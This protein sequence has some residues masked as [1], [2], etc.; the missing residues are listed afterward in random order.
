MKVVS[1]ETLSEALIEIIVHF[2]V[3]RSYVADQGAKPSSADQSVISLAIKQASEHCQTLPKAIFSFIQDVLLK[4][5][6][7][8]SAKDFVARFQQLTGPVMAKG[9]EDTAFYCFNRLISLNE[10]GGNPDRLGMEDIHK[11]LQEKQRTFPHSQLATATH[12][13]KR[14]EDVRARLNLL[15]EIPESWI[16]TVNRW[17]AMNECHRRKNFPD[18]N[19]EYLFYQTLVGAWPLTV[20][21]AQQYMEKAAL[22]SGQH[23]NWLQRNHEYEKALQD[24]ISESL[25]D[26][27]FTTDLEAFT[28]T[29][30]NAAAV[31]SLA[32][33]LV[34]LL[35][36]GIPDI[37]QG[38]ELW[39]RSL[40]DPDNRRP[41][42]F[43]SRQALLEE[44]KLLSPEKIWERRAEG[45]PKL[46][47]I[48]K[49]LY[50]RKGCPDFD[51]LDYQPLIALPPRGDH[52][53]AFV[54][55]EKAIA[56]VPRFL[57]KL[58]GMWDQTTLKLPAGLWHA[59]F[60]GEVFQDEV[61]LE[62]LFRRFPVALLVQKDNP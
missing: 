36:P 27:Q 32:Q 53:F 2:P 45:L 4:Q 21:R 39:D 16:R 44:A 18:R 31:N 15:S 3:Y 58:N 24:F 52:V 43:T 57:L 56:V 28:G 19:A 34:K 25:H 62:T 40:V 47:L 7:G 49:T 33:T 1:R 20:D 54:R 51:A 38:C 22:E 48:Q 23:T 42:D 35:A 30:A 41:V 17:S 55:G 8:K 11:S 26:P 13:T 59:E 10:V 6:S 37:Y 29:L 9:V 50:W 12:D 60:T 5:P 61:M 14:G 46:W